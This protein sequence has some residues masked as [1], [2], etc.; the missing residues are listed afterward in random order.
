MEPLAY[1]S[2]V[3]ITAANVDDMDAAKAVLTG[4]KRK[5]TETGVPPILIHTVCEPQLS[6]GP[7]GLMSPSREQVPRILLSHL[8]CYSNSFLA[9]LGDKAAGQHS[10]API[11]SDLDVPLLDSIPITQ[12]HRD[13]DL[14]V[15]AG[16]AE[17]YVRAWIVMPS[18]VWGRLTGPLV[19][20][21]ISNAKS[22][23]IPRLVRISAARGQAAMIGKGAN[24]WPNV[25]I[26]ECECSLQG[27]RRSL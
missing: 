21:G 17:G 5:H 25:E 7:P 13:I 14:T 16:D 22:Q 19:D 8:S 10:D 9:V 1:A 4:L 2:D 23:Q 24:L 27:H 6:G 12:P 20:D 15:L 18:T 26:S 3:V 11:Y